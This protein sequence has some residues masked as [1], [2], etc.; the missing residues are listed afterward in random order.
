MNR[1]GMRKVVWVLGGFLAGIVMVVA[2]ETRRNADRDSASADGGLLDSGLLELFD[3]GRDA[4]AQEVPCSEWE[5]VSIPWNL[6]EPT[7]E[8]FALGDGCGGPCD[9]SARAIPPGWEPYAGEGSGHNAVLR[10]CMD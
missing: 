3:A 8:V 7:E 6:L 2:C 1:L 4:D 5:V 9:Y 10:R